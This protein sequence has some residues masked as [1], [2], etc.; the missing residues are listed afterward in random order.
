[1]GR[2]KEPTATYVVDKKGKR[3]AVILPIDEYERIM[4]DLSDLAAIAAR[5]NEP[6]I[7]WEKVKRKLKKDGLLHN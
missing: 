3:T 7:P 1:M 2:V 5:K 4:E 6:T